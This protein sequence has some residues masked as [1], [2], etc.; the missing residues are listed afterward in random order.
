MKNI[1]VNVPIN[2]DIIRR[3][4]LVEQAEHFHS[5]KFLTAKYTAKYIRLQTQ[6]G[7]PVNILRM[8]LYG[9]SILLISRTLKIAQ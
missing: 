3:F 7:T 1:S 9:T 2:N 8:E 4:Y 6:R 5:H